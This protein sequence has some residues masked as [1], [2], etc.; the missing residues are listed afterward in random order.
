[1][2]D[3]KKN[4]FFS[5]LSSKIKK[6]KT[7][8]IRQ[9][10][11]DKNHD[12][13]HEDLYTKKDLLIK[14]DNPKKD[15]IDTLNDHG[16]DIE[17][18]QNTKNNFFLR[19]K[20]SLKTTKKNL[21]DKIY[22]IFLSKKIDEVLFE[23]LEEK[24][25]LAD[26]GINTTNRI[27]SNLIKDVNREDLK[28]SEKLY[29]LLKRKMFNILKK[30]EIPLEISSHSPF[31]ILVVGVNGTGKT[32]TVA[33][34][35]EKYKLEG[36]SIMLAAADTFRAAGIEQLQTLGKLNNI[37]VIA[38]RSGSDPAAVIFDAVKSAK[39]KKIDVLIIDTAG[40]LHNKLHLIEELKKIVRVIKKIDISAPHEKLLIIDSCNGQNTIQ[41][42]E[43]FHKALNLTGIIIT[44]LDGTAKGGV[45][46][47]LADQFQIPIRYIGIGEKMQ[48]LGHFNSQEFIESI[49]T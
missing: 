39:S 24:M 11:T 36:K 45:V 42:T 10:N 16:K 25:L 38:Q 9:N 49:F 31:V 1:M 7:I 37:P 21:G 28:N 5:W 48:D 13:N 44:K 3:S 33:K 47:S 14:Q 8:D 32:T 2:K 17:K 19:L 34:L 40:R 20:K 46:F 29:F 12:I 22:Q 18:A 6:K 30:V 35:A 41:Q 27:I 26:I 4:G 15:E 43:I 23:E